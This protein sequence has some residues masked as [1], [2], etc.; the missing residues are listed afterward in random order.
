MSRRALLI[1]VSSYQVPASLKPF[2]SAKRNVEAVGRILANPDVGGFEVLPPLFDPDPMQLQEAV[3]EFL[4]QCQPDDLA[5]LFFSGQ[6]VRDERGKLFFSTHITRHTPEGALIKYSAVPVSFVQELLSSC[7]ARHKVLILDWGVSGSAQSLPAPPYNE[8]LSLHQ[9]LGGASW[10]VLLSSD[11]PQPLPEHSGSDLSLYSHYLVEGLATGAADLDKD[12]LVSLRDLHTYTSEHIRQIDPNQ[13]PQIIALQEAVLRIPLARVPVLGSR[14]Q[15]QEAVKRYV[16]NGS[17]SPVGRSIL[18]R[19]R[20][21]LKLSPAEALDI[22]NEVLRPYRE[23]Q[24]NEQRYRRALIEALKQEY[25]LS[26]RTLR[27]LRDL[28]TL[29]GL[30][31]AVAATIQQ[32]ASRPFAEA[33]AQRLGK[34]TQYRQAVQQEI[35]AQYPLSNSARQRLRRVQFA[36]GL[37]DADTHSL[38]QEAIAQFE[39]QQEEYHRQLRHYREAVLEAIQQEE[40]ISN[41]TRLRL[42]KLQHSLGLRPSDAANVEQQVND[43]M[44]AAR[45]VYRSNLDTYRREFEQA[46]AQAHIPTLAVRDRLQRLQQ[47]LG[48]QDTDIMQTEAAVEA[49][50]KAQRLQRYEQAFNQQ[51]LAA[52]VLD[53]ATLEQI[54]QSLLPLQESLMLKDEELQTIQRHLIAQA[55]AQR[56]EYHQ[57]LRQYGERYFSAIQKHQSAAALAELQSHWR[58]ELGLREVDAR[59]VEQLINQRYEQYLKQQTAMKQTGDSPPEGAGA[60]TPPTI[61]A[62][63]ENQQQGAETAL[64]TTDADHTRSAS[65]Q[66]LMFPDPWEDAASTRP[67]T[68]PKS[69]SESAPTMAERSTAQPTQVDEARLTFPEDHPNGNGTPRSES[70]PSDAVPPGLGQT[71]DALLTIPAAWPNNTPLPPTGEGVDTEV[72]RPLSAVPTPFDA[73][74]EADY[75]VKPVILPPRSAAPSP[76]SPTPP[77]QRRNEDDLSSQRGVDYS[78]LRELLIHQQWRDADQLTFQLMLQAAGRSREGWLHAEALGS[79]PCVDLN[80]LN[81]LWMKYSE[82][83]FGFAAQLQVFQSLPTPTQKDPVKRDSKLAIEFAKRVKWMM[84]ERIYPVFLPYDQLDFSLRAPFGHLPALWFWQLPPMEALKSGAIGSSRALGGADSQR[85][86]VALMRQAQ[87]CKVRNAT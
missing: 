18:E 76:V 5:V 45:A 60:E 37:T 22:E 72:E 59:E 31:P 35:A 4:R 27:E 82:G 9:Q 81:Q 86:L 65:G 23:Q 24:A 25:P 30:S 44:Q 42:Q 34:L 84:A 28:Q 71:A 57:K 11:N 70:E 62:A 63:A 83:R 50:L 33:A 48:L 64:L 8:D 2:P 73:G 21:P 32:E 51:L 15:Y 58:Q 26:D 69:A 29:L 38:E 79:F 49:S 6:A 47:T 10:G 12:G 19:M 87:E 40:P 66:T 67:D 75:T 80:T 46:V 13:H 53:A 41:A 52:K 16:E 56:L 39:A 78:G 85:M 36:L 20:S 55:K 61:P 7:A 43:E 14:R 68:P 3:E 1:G 17:I 77:V 54:R 74:Y